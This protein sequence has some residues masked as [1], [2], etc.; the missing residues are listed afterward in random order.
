MTELYGAPLVIF[1]KA[2]SDQ[3]AAA[4]TLMKWLTAPK[5]TA[6][7]AE[8]TGYMPVRKSA[9]KLMKS[10][11]KQHPQQ[12]ANVA[13]S[14]DAIIEPPLAGWTKASTDLNT[15]LLQA[16]TGA[17]SPSVAMKQAATQVNS[18]LSATSGR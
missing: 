7:W 17:M 18:D 5:Q 11:Y 2:P 6:Y 14:D 4:W 16:L 10:Y 12:R 13:E 1:K 9:L 15:V 8:N 3:K